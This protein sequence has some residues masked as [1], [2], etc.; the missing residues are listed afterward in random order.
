VARVAGRFS[1]PEDRW[2]R[3]DSTNT[4]LATTS[5]VA[6]GTRPL[7]VDGTYVMVADAG[8]DAFVHWRGSATDVG[9]Y[10]LVQ[11]DE[12]IRAVRIAGPR[13]RHREDAADFAMVVT[14]EADDRA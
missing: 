11:G 14:E 9:T 2:Y 1:G 4:W 8:P 6:G 7:F 12:E 5:P 10:H 13:L 3:I